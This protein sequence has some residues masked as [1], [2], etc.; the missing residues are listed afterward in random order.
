MDPTPAALLRTASDPAAEALRLEA[1]VLR[2]AQGEQAALAELFE[3]C[4]ARVHAVA[5]R[6]LGRA[7]DAEEAVL[8]TFTQAWE[9]APE[10]SPARAEVMTWLLG[11][12]W[13]RA[14]DRLRRERRHRRAEPLHP[15]PG[16][17][18]YTG[19]MDDPTPRLLDALDAQSALAAASAG[20]SAIQQR[21]LALAFLEDLSHAEIADRTGLPLGTVKSHLR[22]ALAR[23][24]ALLGGRE[25]EHG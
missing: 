5:L 23:L 25:P 15:E 4:S 8:D 19:Q 10:Y 16:A 12:A 21:L 22:R 3:R 24:A 14:I 17:E 18:A 11:M 1:L 2:M 7:E 13:S 6:V 9:R 20:L